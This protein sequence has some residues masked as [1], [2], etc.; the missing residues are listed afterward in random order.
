MIEVRSL[1]FSYGEC[2]V[3][4][5]VNFTLEAGKIA[6][7]LGPNGRGKTTLLKSIVGLL[8]PA[9]GHARLYGRLGYV[10]QRTEIAFAYKVIDIVVMGRAAHVG[11]FRAPGLQDY[12]HARNA[13]SQ[14]GLSEFAEQ[15]FNQLS[16][17]ERQLV[18]IAGHWHLSAM[19]WSLM[20]LLQLLIFAIRIW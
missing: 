1:G 8:K 6:A 20:N 4:R 16:G 15:H 17:G 5:D 7:I 13:L 14:L 9:K 10:A 19:C 11:M 18:M 3:F 2:W 12:E